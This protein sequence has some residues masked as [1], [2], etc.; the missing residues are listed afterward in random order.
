MPIKHIDNKAD[1]AKM[2]LDPFF[3][4][5]AVREVK[6]LFEKG[7]KYKTCK[8]I[9]DTLEKAKETIYILPAK[10]VGT[11]FMNHNNVATV[12]LS[13][14]VSLA[15]GNEVV[16]VDPLILVF[17]ELGHA[18]Q[19]VTRKQWFEESMRKSEQANE[20]FYKEIEDDNLKQYEYPLCKEM[21]QPQRFR[22]EYFVSASEALRQIK[23]AKT[24]QTAVRGKLL[25]K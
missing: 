16:K 3:D 7:N 6:K 19:W 22:Y 15:S 18:A 24:I 2:D 17:H 20:K 9:L 25:G 4:G 13:Q 11:V 21:S 1:A 12:N 14:D 5:T 10:E 8:K 23:A